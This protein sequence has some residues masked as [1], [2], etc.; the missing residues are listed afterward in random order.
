M[1]TLVLTAGLAL[2][3]VSSCTC[4]SSSIH[5]QPLL[6]V[7]LGK[8]GTNG[9]VN[10]GAV[11]VGDTKSLVITVDNNG[12]ADFVPTVSP[13]DG[14]AVFSANPS[15]T[16]H[17]LAGLSSTKLTITYAPTG[18][19]PNSGRF[20]VS[21]PACDTTTV[22]LAGTGVAECILKILP[23]S[24]NFPALTGGQS[25]TLALTLQNDGKA[26]CNPVS[27]QLDPASAP[28]FTLPGGNITGKLGAGKAGPLSVT[29]TSA[30]TAAPGSY[31]GALLI[32][33]NDAKNPHQRVL[34]TASS[35]DSGYA[36]SPW[37]KWH[38]NSGNTGLSFVDAS[39]SKGQLVWKTKIGGPA[40]VV[41]D[42]TGTYL[43]SPSIGADGTIY[44]A[45]FGF[46]DGAPGVFVALSPDG[47]TKWSVTIT[48]PE[49]TCAESTPTVAADDTVYLMTGGDGVSWD[50]KGPQFYHFGQDGSI[51]WSTRNEFDGYDSSPGIAPDGTL[52]VINDDTER[53]EAFK[54]DKPVWNAGTACGPFSSGGNCC[55]TT[56]AGQPQCPGQLDSGH[57]ETFSGLLTSDNRSYWTAQGQAWGLSAAGAQIWSK[58]LPG[59]NASNVESNGK[60]APALAAD[61]SI[62]VSEAPL[63]MPTDPFGNPS[64][65]T[66]MLQ[67]F[68]LDPNSGTVR[69]QFVSGSIDM[70]SR[71]SAFLGFSSPAILPDGKSMVV[72]HVDGLHAFAPSPNGGATGVELWFF[73]CGQVVSSPAVSADGT[74]FFGSADG[75]LYAVKDGKKVWANRI[76]AAVNSSPAIGADGTIYVMADDGFLYAVK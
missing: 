12:S 29:F 57:A 20:T 8:S 9:V 30:K 33:S 38:R 42:S 58:W 70:G 49:A 53:V 66:T 74:V 73:P 71:D 13:I 56:M 21:C 64:N 27:A 68:A 32:D 76:G 4:G 62:Y 26:D 19:G 10:F 3:L 6:F 59:N 5:S 75:N 50:D 40:S 52:Y 17:N 60:A 35:T 45:G 39:G 34:L 15:G 47:K 7:D 51:I 72:G 16:L 44:Q 14:D 24:L 11:H 36:N 65:E 54:D 22:E 31:Q 61:G 43:A 46:S 23:T 28:N 41:R 55:D 67:V 48:R 1:R 37:P 2:L 63:V 18:L 25:K 69:W